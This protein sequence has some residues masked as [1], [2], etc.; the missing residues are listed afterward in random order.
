MPHSQQHDGHLVKRQKVVVPPKP[1]S[2]TPK[3][4]RIF[5]PFRVRPRN[6]SEATYRSCDMDKLI[7]SNRL[8]A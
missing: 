7:P 2:S 8:S 5:A 6:I 1:A 3:A 4:S